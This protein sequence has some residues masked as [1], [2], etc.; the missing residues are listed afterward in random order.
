MDTGV[1]ALRTDPEEWKTEEDVVVVERNTSSEIGLTLEPISQPSSSYDLESPF[2]EFE[3][4]EKEEKEEEEEEKWEEWTTEET[5]V[6]KSTPEIL[7]LVPSRTRNLNLNGT[8]EAYRRY[9][10]RSVPE[11]TEAVENGTSKPEVDV[12]D[13]PEV[14]GNSKDT[15][16]TDKWIVLE[17]EVVDTPVEILAQLRRTYN[18][19]N[20]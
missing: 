1:V 12:D 13:T 7:Y 3:V 4:N 9:D 20:N 8:A 2:E 16:S 5:V 10:A 15:D 11:S 18:D 6:I 17:E 19:L 14:N